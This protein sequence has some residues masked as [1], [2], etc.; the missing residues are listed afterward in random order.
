MSFIVFFVKNV[1]IFW[2]VQI[3]I[4]RMICSFSPGHDATNQIDKYAWFGCFGSKCCN[5][6]C[7][8]CIYMILCKHYGARS[9]CYFM[10]I[11]EQP[12]QPYSK[13][14]LPFDQVLLDISYA[15]DMKTDNS[16]RAK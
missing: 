3:I 2:E 6:I 11:W 14:E 15:E 13:C 12:N 16:F 5:F 7:A 9:D 8:M 4:F 1:N 10:V